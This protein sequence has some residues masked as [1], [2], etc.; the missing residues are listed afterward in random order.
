MVVIALNFLRAVT[1][2]DK[3]AS[4]QNQPA[5]KDDSPLLDEQ[6]LKELVGA[7]VT[8]ALKEKATSED[9]AGTDDE[10]DL[11]A[12]Q[13]VIPQIEKYAPSRACFA[14]KD[15]RV[16]AVAQPAGAGLVRDHEQRRKCD[17]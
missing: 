15:Q 11:M 8:A 5:S 3:E 1:Q 2:R 16:H 9:G 6:S 12:V 4:A 17:G 14:G 13:S 7:I 10:T